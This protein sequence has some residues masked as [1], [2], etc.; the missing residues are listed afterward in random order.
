MELSSWLG[1]VQYCKNK[2]V[3]TRNTLGVLTQKF[4]FCHFSRITNHKSHIFALKYS[5]FFF[6]MLKTSPS[7]LSVSKTKWEFWRL[8]KWDNRMVIIE[9]T[10]T[11]LKLHIIRL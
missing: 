10:L 7:N 9:L 11:R 4:P 5:L 2:I 6:N 1:F 3:S 8:R